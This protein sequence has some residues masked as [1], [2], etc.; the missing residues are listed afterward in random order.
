METI[1]LE[2]DYLIVGSG[3]V[4]MAFA[5]VILTETDARLIM[6]DSYPKP[7]GHWNKAYPYV[8]LHQPSQ[9]YGV[10]SAELSKGRKDQVGWNQ[11]LNDLASGHEVLAYFDEVMRHRF[12]PSGRVEYYPMCDYHGDNTFKSRLSGQVY[13][14]SRRK[15]VDATHLKTS[16]PSTHRPKFEIDAD[17]WFMPLNDLADIE[18]APEGYTIIG[19]GKT[20]IDAVLW[21]LE[22]RVDP[23]KIRWIMPR[24]AWL[25]DR[26][27]T[28]PTDD[29]FFSSLGSQ[30]VQFEAIAGSS[31]IA[32]MFDRLEAGGYFLRIDPDVRPSMFHGATISR[33]E[34]EQLRRVKNIVRRGRVSRIRSDEIILDEAVLPTHS[35]IVHVDCS[36][37]AVSNE[38]IKPIFDG[39]IITPQMVRSYQP[40]FSAAL[41]AHVEA[42]YDTDA[43][44]NELCG[45]VPLPNHDTDF[46]RFTAAFMLNQYKWSQDA[47]M[48]EWLLHNRLDGFSKLV[49][50]VD[51]ED[52]DK[53]AVLGRIKKSAP[54]AVMKL[55]HYLAQL[56][57]GDR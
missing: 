32:D 5:D 31:S 7:G 33:M 14:V 19:A 28:Q 48:R 38:E 27:N 4:G 13:H 41:I 11:G 8:T 54:L 3:A 21:L 17:V 20:G 10:S 39:D 35:N 40:V 18:E 47:G 45:V 12:L 1:D 43:A 34:L 26:E 51:R 6:V 50:G 16:V 36:A 25:L 46:I 37:R 30:A 29:F 42:A 55:Q 22:N 23:D 53:M 2:T 52:A 57:K 9:Y 24:D 44:K 49:A 15:H 56:E